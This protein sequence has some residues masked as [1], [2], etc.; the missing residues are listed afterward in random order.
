MTAGIRSSLIAAWE[1]LSAGAPG[2]REWR[3]LRVDLAHKLDV[4][5]AIHEVDRVRSVL[6]ECPVALAP[7][8]RLR[9]ES[10]GLRLVDDRDGAD[11]IRR[12][13]LSLE[14]L[15][16]DEVFVVVAEDLIDSSRAA[17]DPQ[18]AI[19]ALGARLSAWQ[20]CL[21]L[22]RDG[23]DE[24]R[25]LGLYG[26]LVALERVAAVVGIARAV[27]VWTG[28]ERGLHDFEAGSFALEVKTSR[29]ASSAVRIGS[30]DQLDPSNLRELVMLRVAVVPDDAGEGLDDLITRTRAAADS[31]GSSV[32]RATDQRLLMSGY[33]DLGERDT[34]FERFAVAAI[35]AYRVADA[36]PRLTRE[37]VPAAVLSAEYRLDVTAAAGSLL[38]ADDV[39][40]LFEQ[41]REGA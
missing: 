17:G 10:E 19:T 14:R 24:E 15:E 9:F 3:A 20:T 1:S 35:E 39:P 37:S 23:F 12:I 21:K 2:A 16:L 22:R 32:R 6:F 13:A 7:T 28:P 26:E 34:R 29:G 25:I 27:A 4:F 31:A 41:F 5:A 18:E 33:V 40:V 30:L 11:G 36:F 8:W 38:A